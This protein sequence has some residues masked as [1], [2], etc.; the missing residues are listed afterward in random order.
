[1]SK[2][3][4]EGTRG[5][6]QMCLIYARENEYSLILEFVGIFSLE[7]GRPGTRA[8]CAL[9]HG[10][11]TIAYLPLSTPIDRV[12]LDVVRVVSIDERGAVLICCIVTGV[13]RRTVAWRG[14]R[15]RDERE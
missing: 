15:V 1:M 12:M 2:K 6:T 11:H 14:H 10:P 13:H 5:L 7:Q 9:I 3:I 4:A 8:N